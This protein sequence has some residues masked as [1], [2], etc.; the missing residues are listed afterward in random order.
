MQKRVI[1]SYCFMLILLMVAI[2]RIYQ[3]IMSD[4]ITMTAYSQG[5]YALNVVSARGVIYDRNMR[6]LV[7]SDQRYIASVMPSPESLEAI[8][9]LVG[10]ESR[11][12]YLE[13]FT[14]GF[15]FTM[16]ISD[17]NLYARGVDVFRVPVR[18]GKQQLAPHVIGYMGSNANNGVAGIERAYN[19]LLN[20][21]GTNIDIIYN[22]DAIGRIMG[23]NNVSV[24][25]SGTEKAMGGIV[26]TIDSNIQA[27]A[28]NALADGCDRG[29]AV[30]LDVIT[31]DILGMASL[32]VYD[33]NYIAN[34]LERGDA[35]FINRAVSGYSIGSA[36]KVLI[37]TAA[38]ENGIPVSYSYQCNGSIDINGQTF[39]CNNHSIHGE[40]D[41]E[42]AL[43]V[44][45]NTYFINL[46]AE[47]EPEFV[48]AF[49][50]NMGF[51]ASAE[52]AVGIETQSGNLP[53]AGELSNK[54]DYANFSFGQGSTSV[55]PLQMAV[56]VATLAN[57]GMSVVPRLVLGETP[58][59]TAI[60]NHSPIYNPSLVIEPA[61]ARR[62][63]GLMVS[64]VTDGSG[65]TA[66]PIRGGAGGKTS[67]A[68]TG[69]KIDGV[70]EVHAWFTGFYPAGNPRYS[71][72]VFVEGGVSGE[73]VAAP[74]FKQIADGIGGLYD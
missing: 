66:K 39:R 61:T 21:Y 63:A 53:D 23:G 68:Q 64:V 7:N 31:G 43:Q 56:A 32:P 1:F 16:E 40:I 54:A 35:P 2:F 29:A 46:A 44:S 28:Q 8:L 18:Y 17:R 24:R 36:F 3:I 58:D 74:I 47:I 22:V 37:A 4:Y 30:V 49:L 38:L 52:L 34:S 51:G 20:S 70:E 12:H 5:K 14:T 33:Q 69:R 41:M 60:V 9:P 10:E 67:S 65:R 26:L 50:S 71:I 11:E 62:V 15:P 48:L 6:P 55:T 73:Q 72:I 45:C 57:G 19:D 27:I 13:R 42:R 59:G 25:R